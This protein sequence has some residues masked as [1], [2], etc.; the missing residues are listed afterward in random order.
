MPIERDIV[1][2]LDRLTLGGPEALDGLSSSVTQLRGVLTSK[3]VIG[4]GV[5]DKET[6]GKPTGELALCFY[7][8]R[9][10]PLAR[11]SAA[12]AVP[13]GVPPALSRKVI[14]TDVVVLGK[15]HLDGGSEEGLIQPGISI[16]H[17]KTTVGTLGALVRRGKQIQLLS[18]AHVLALSG[19]AKL[20]DSILSPGKED[21]GRFPRD[22]VARLSR[23]KKFVPGGA[24][25]NTVDCALAT[26]LKTRMGALRA[27]ILKLGLPR[28]TMPP[29]RGMK[30]M[31]VGR[32]SGETAGVVRDIHFRFVFRYEGIG[33]VGF[34][35]QV[36]CT[37]YSSPGDSGS[38]V[39]DKRTKK[40]VGLHFAGAPA[41]SVF[42]PIGEVLSA[43]GAEL[44]TEALE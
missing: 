39:L 1:G 5:A 2:V 10:L 40:A 4:V 13:P 34:L 18:N 7:V 9:K 23:V 30:V 26:P 6:A 27:E 28:G 31:K 8:E 33:D 42:C 22:V 32:T 3:N 17:F 38:L 36:L 15:I 12:Q 14:S 19:K 41:G 24:F 11:L 44:I 35:D 20:G 16:G 29:K 21:G 43:L 25:V 37:R